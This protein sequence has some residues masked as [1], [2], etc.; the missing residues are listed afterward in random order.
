MSDADR[1]ELPIGQQRIAVVPAQYSIG[2]YSD[3]PIEWTD[4]I[5]SDGKTT[6]RVRHYDRETVAEPGP[7]QLVRL[8]HPNRY[9]QGV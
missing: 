3:V 5:F 1:F 2:H 4:S 7:F 9:R 8:R 6:Q